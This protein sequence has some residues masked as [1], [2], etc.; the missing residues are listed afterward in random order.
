VLIMAAEPLVHF[1]KPQGVRS[2]LARAFIL[3]MLVWYLGRPLLVLLIKPRGQKRDTL[4]PLSGISVIIPCHNTVSTIDESLRSIL[5]QDV[6]G[7]VEVILVENNSTDGSLD[8]LL[9]L[10]HRFPGVVRVLQVRPE[11]N[12]FPAAVAVNYG[13]QHAR[14][15]VVVRMDDDTILGPQALREITKEIGRPGVVGVA[16]NLRV[17]NSTESLWTRMQ[18][19]EYLLAMELDRRSQAL[20][21]SVVCCSGGMSA[22]RRSTLIQVGG[23]ST[24]RSVS[25]DLDI[26]LKCQR[27]G[28]VSMA[29]KAIGFTE[30]PKNPSALL[31]QRIRWGTNGT[32]GASL[33]AKGFL[34]RK[35][36]FQ[37]MMG[38]YGLPAKFVA[39]LRELLPFALADVFLQV[40]RLHGRLTGLISLFAIPTAVLLLQFAILAPAL[41]M[42]QGLRYMPMTPVFLFVYGPLVTVSRC[43]GGLRAAI[44]FLPSKNVSRSE[45]FSPPP[46]RGPALA[47]RRSAVASLA[48][49][50]WAAGRMRLRRPAI[51][52]T[53]PETATVG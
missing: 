38:F 50:L 39:T 4:D 7:P 22:F 23:Y 53:A 19:M 14:Y 13:V 36:W 9:S 44:L 37:G 29:P 46:V 33:H 16:C 42:R 28:R 30:C 49:G 40:F 41:A 45:Y 21:D 25:E 2:W 47:P 18:S 35:Y 27:V 5:D 48:S 32:V 31:K 11:P 34:N 15:D 17:A 52:R 8:T 1:A 6:D 43:I 51:S 10:E 24:V 12:E 3:L 20:L 26:T